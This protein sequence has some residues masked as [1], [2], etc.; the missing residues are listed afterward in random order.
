MPLSRSTRLSPAGIKP[1]RRL[2][3]NDGECIMGTNQIDPMLVCLHHQSDRG[4]YR[5]TSLS[6]CAC[7]LLSCRL[8]KAETTSRHDWADVLM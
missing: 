6:L 4:I 3:E 8:F 1:R 2:L 7:G 5:G